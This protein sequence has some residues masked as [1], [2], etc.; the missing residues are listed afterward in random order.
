MNQGISGFPSASTPVLRWR[1]DAFYAQGGVFVV[2]QGC[3]TVRAFVRG[4]CSAGDGSG[5]AGGTGGRGFGNVPVTPGQRITITGG[6]SGA[7][8]SFGSFITCTA[9]AG[10]NNV[11][12]QGTV[13]FAPTVQNQ[14]NYTS[15]TVH[16]A[17]MLDGTPVGI[18]VNNVLGNTEEVA[19]VV[20]LE[21]METV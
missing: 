10:G 17:R 15:F 11:N 4:S 14:L 9:S 1:R 5:G 8:A 6:G 18:N 16:A 7:T 20:F 3:F 2:P 12:S 21:Y 13:T 19:T